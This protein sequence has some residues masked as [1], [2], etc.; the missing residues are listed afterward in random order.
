MSADNTHLA[1]EEAQ[2]INVV[3]AVLEQGSGPG[4]TPVGPPR[5]GV[6]TLGRRPAPRKPIRIGSSA[7]CTICQSRG[8]FSGF[9]SFVRTFSGP[10]L[11]GKL[12]HGHQCAFRPG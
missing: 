6:V 4:P 10:V 9:G 2:Q 7:M 8:P 3:D 1:D 12:E 5:A 11:S